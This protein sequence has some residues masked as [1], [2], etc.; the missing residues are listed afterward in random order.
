MST[1]K[2]TVYNINWDVFYALTEDK[3]SNDKLS[4]NDILRIVLKSYDIFSTPDVDMCI[5]AGELRKKV[6]E[7]KENKNIIYLFF[8]TTLLI[9]LKRVISKDDDKIIL[10]DK[11]I[12]NMKRLCGDV[13]MI[14]E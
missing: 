4:S 9:L 3:L 13:E 10:N 12:F 5:L 6:T 1:E 11:I 7:L 14:W 8:D 2:G